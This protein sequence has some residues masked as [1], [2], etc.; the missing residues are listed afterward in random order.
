MG[1]GVSEANHAA[2]K[3]H[4]PGAEPGAEA[5]CGLYLPRLLHP[6]SV[7]L[8][9]GT[10]HPPQ[11]WRG[12]L[13]TIHGVWKASEV[14]KRGDLEHQSQAITATNFFEC[15]EMI[16]VLGGRRDYLMGLVQDCYMTNEQLLTEF[17]FGKTNT[18]IRPQYLY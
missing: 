10:N 4:G 11:V 8:H 9:R 17:V 13:V 16:L 18:I 3:A 2:A 14:Q 15:L 6:L 12:L 7:V 5:H 1:R